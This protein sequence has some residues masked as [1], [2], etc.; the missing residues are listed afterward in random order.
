MEH[1]HY[2]KNRFA[3]LVMFFI[4]G[5]LFASW[6]SR[7]PFI[8]NQHELS[9]G[10]LGVVLLGVA[11][12]V[13]TALSAAGG[14][15]ARYGSQ[16][17]T[18]AAAF[19]MCALLPLLAIMPNALLLWF[20]LF[21]FRMAMSTMDVA[22]NAQAVSAEKRIGRPLMSSFH[23]AFSIGGICGAGIGSLSARLMVEP[24]LHFLCIT[25]LFLSSVLFWKRY[26]IFE[27]SSNRA[28]VG[29]VFSLPPRVTWTI[30]VVALISAFGEGAMADWSAVYLTTV[31]QTGEDIAALGFGFFSGCMTIGRLSGDRPAYRLS[32][33]LT[34][35]IG[36][37]VAGCGLLLAV[38]VPHV[39]STLV[40]C[41][42]A[43]LGLSVVM[44][45]VFRKAGDLPGVPAGAGIAGVA[46]IGYAGFLAGPPLLGLIAEGSS[47]RIS[48]LIVALLMFSLIVM[49]RALDNHTPSE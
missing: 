39:V 13:L 41:S 10:S 16:T 20:G 15:I 6:V 29:P 37:L 47:L 36:G 31:V 21:L 7:I 44:P 43:D 49:A 8:R 48:L 28:S 5:G 42:V 34:V 4:N 40:G 14:L 24:R 33:V 9:E 3:I 46:T 1:L 22:M 35:R 18:V 26:L 19:C 45:T 12:G 32:S 2:V 11:A 25:V 17:V 27:S 23:A 38:L 30:G